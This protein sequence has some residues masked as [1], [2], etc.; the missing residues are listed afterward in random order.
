[1]VLLPASAA[2]NGQYLK[3]QCMDFGVRWLK[4]LGWVYRT[5]DKAIKAH[6]YTSNGCIA[7]VLEMQKRCNYV[8]APGGPTILMYLHAIVGLVYL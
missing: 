8:T 7:S 3:A 2:V 1:M 6:I 5:L 4:L